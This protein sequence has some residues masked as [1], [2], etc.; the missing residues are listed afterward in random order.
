MNTRERSNAA[1]TWSINSWLHFVIGAAV[2]V[3]LAGGIELAN[4]AG[5][6]SGPRV[7]SSALF[8]AQIVAVALVAG[9][10]LWLMLRLWKGKGDAPDF[11]DCVLWNACLVGGLVM[12]LR[13]FASY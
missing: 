12:S 8:G 1:S 11:R 7:L 9:I 3:L 4:G 2:L 5:E 10:L 6:L 13:M